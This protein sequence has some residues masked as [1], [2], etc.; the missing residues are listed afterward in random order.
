MILRLYINEILYISHN[1]HVHKS[2]NKR[3]FSKNK[4]TSKLQS[5]QY[6]SRF[7]NIES[8]IKHITN[9]WELIK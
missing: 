8:D 1:K 3:L 5:K 9:A 6:L 7:R 2:Q 4:V